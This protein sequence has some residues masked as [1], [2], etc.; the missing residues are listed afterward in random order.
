[1]QAPQTLAPNAVLNDDAV[2]NHIVAD[3]AGAISER[4]GETAERRSFRAQIATQ[5]IV[6]LLPRDV[7]QAMLAGHA[8]MFHAVLTDSVHQTLRGEVDTMRRATRSNIVALNKCFHMNADRLERCQ[9]A[10]PAEAQRTE[11]AP[12]AMAET[13]VAPDT[14]HEIGATGSPTDVMPDPSCPPP[15]ETPAAVLSAPSL[16]ENPVLFHPTDEQIDACLANPEAMAALRANDSEAFARAIGFDFAHPT[17]GQAAA[18]RANPAAV[19]A[20][21]ARDAGAFLTAMGLDLSGGNRLARAPAPVAVAE[22]PRPLNRYQ[23]RH[24]R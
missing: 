18:C 15:G 13:L 6:A 14:I 1:M 2:L 16:A 12:A 3:I 23:R 5:M 17:P 9:A 10:R 19:A 20:L 22:T 4:P 7:L 24:P 21:E 8:V 11:E